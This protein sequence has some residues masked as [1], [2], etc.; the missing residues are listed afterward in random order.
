[1]AP[2]TARELDAV[3]DLAARPRLDARE[4]LGDVLAA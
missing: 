3:A 2:G 4:H 1:V